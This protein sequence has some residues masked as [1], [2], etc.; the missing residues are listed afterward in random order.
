MIALARTGQGGNVDLGDALA[1]TLGAVF[2]GGGTAAI[3]T[4]LTRRRLTRVEAADQLADSA[5]DLL[6]TVKA[7]VRAD[8]A[9]MRTELASARA[10]TTELRAALRGATREAEQLS[11]YL[12]RLTSAIHDPNMTIE[13]LRVLV[14]GGPPNSMSL[15]MSHP[16]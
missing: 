6:N 15:W 5:I 4:A 7:D 1:A 9:L 2:G 3:V 14:G 10:E 16:D 13:R 12:S 11:N 8:M